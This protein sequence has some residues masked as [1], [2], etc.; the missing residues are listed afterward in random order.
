MR[1]LV[2]SAAL[3]LGVASPAFAY[4]YVPQS[5]ATPA[6]YEIGIYPATPALFYGANAY[7][8]VPTRGRRESYGDS[9][10]SFQPSLTGGG[11]KGYNAAVNYPA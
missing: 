2:I 10:F 3:L 11:T 6:V 9:A 5:A 7:A 8:M 1:T 4:G